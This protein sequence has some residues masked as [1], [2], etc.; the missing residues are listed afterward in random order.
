MHDFM[1]YCLHTYFRATGWN[2]DNHYSNLSSTSRSLLNFSIPY[3]FSF[4]FSKIPTSLFKSSY[5][6][7]AIP[8]LQG[9]VGYLFT[10]RPLHINAADAA[11]FSELAERIFVF[12]RGT[13]RKIPAEQER[14][15]TVTSAV[16]DYLLYGQLY[17]PSGR[18]EGIYS[19][20]ISENEQFVLT[21]VSSPNQ[22]GTS[23]LTAQ[24]QYD[25]G[26]RC[27]EISYTTYKSIFGLRTLWNV[28]QLIEAPQVPG[29]EKIKK[30]SRLS[31]GGE[32]YYIAKEKSGGLSTGIRYRSFDERPFIATVI[33]NPMMGHLTGGYTQAVSEDLTLCSRYDFNVYSYE[34]DLAVGAEWRVKGEGVMK[35]KFSV[36]DGFALMF[37]GQ[38]RKVH[39]TFGVTADIRSQSPLRSIGLQIQYCS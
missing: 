33:C 10:S 32:L 11:E 9:S 17:L 2:D 18:L 16:K 6:L 25:N 5:S 4:Q 26:R 19:K 29:E 20:R 37:D 1:E 31:V 23:H 27:N 21:G 24:Y 13:T 38:Y 39:F 3:G 28:G 15:E 14:G 36:K 12:S 34:S 35:T 22:P 7:Q 8:A 30:T